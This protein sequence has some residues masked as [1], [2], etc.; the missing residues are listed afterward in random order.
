MT[1]TNRKIALI[2]GGGVRSPLVVYG[3]NESAAALGVEEMVLYDPDPQRVQLMVAMGRAVVTEFGGD[4][5]LRAAASLED[6]IEGADFVL[7]SIRIGGIAQRAADERVSIDQGYPGQETTGPAG[8]AM[9]LRT[10]RVSIAQARLV[11][12]LSPD[13]WLVNFTNPA[14]L[15]TQAVTTHTRAKI[16][17]ICDTPTELF[18]NIAHALGAHHDAVECDYVGLNHL[19]WVRGVR[20][21]GEEV[22]DRLLQDDALL[23]QLYLAPL[24]DFDMIRELRLIPTEYLF[25]Y[26]E[27]RRA[28][29]NQRTQGGSRGAEIETL[30]HALIA[31]LGS[32]LQAGDGHGAVQAYAAYLNQRSGSY[33]KL[34]AEG[35]S[36]FD[37]GVSLQADPFRVSTGYHRIAIDVM[38]ALTGA[39]PAK[40]VVNVRNQGAIADLPDDDIVEISS[41]ID[42]DRIVP[43]PTAPLPDAVHGLIRAVKAYERAAIEAVLSGSRLTARKAMLIHPAIGEWTPSHDL[44]ES[45]FGHLSD[46]GQCLCQGPMHWHG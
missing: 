9:A 19:G 21:H 17:G 1:A 2:G 15:I 16:V 42:R 38:S 10:V 34:E 18:H 13:A 7:N 23:R 8:V 35:G 4:L 29:A 26:Y 5:R 33:M 45:L 31:T 40:I 37:A 32:R 46:D 25:F 22:I 44:L 39:V 3:V 20:L 43:C 12:R 41:H 24:F 28:L 27:R 11:E 30:N 36:A 14:G 6:A